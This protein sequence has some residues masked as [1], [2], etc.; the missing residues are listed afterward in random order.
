MNDDAI[1]KENYAD[2][3]NFFSALFTFFLNFSFSNRVIK[4][5]RDYF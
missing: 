4:Y 3:L 5:A 2:L 1:R